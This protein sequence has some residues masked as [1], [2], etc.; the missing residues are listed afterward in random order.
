MTRL[1]LE[2]NDPLPE[3]VSPHR[4]YHPACARIVHRWQCNEYSVKVYNRKRN[5]KLSAITNANAARS[6]TTESTAP[7]AFKDK[8]ARAHDPML[9]LGADYVAL[10][11]AGQIKTIKG[12]RQLVL[13]RG[14]K[15]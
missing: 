1:C 7:S 4:K 10:K 14:A 13:T 8:L 12:Q 2:C 3:G 6:A 5:A 15:P 11:L 9:H